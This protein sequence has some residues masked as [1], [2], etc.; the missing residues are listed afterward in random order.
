MYKRQDVVFIVKKSSSPS[1]P[2]QAAIDQVTGKF[3][4]KV[5][6]SLIFSAIEISL[7]TSDGLEI[8]PSGPVMRSDKIKLSQ[9]E[10]DKTLLDN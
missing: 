7:F 8:G 4:V 9:T 2:G 6:I 5:K 10:Q 3:A 1:F